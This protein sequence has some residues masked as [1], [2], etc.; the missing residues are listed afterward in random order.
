MLSTTCNYRE[1]NIAKL[2]LI[3][4]VVLIHCNL[5]PNLPDFIISENV[6]GIII[7][8]FISRYLCKICVP[9]FFM[10][11]GFLF[12]RNISIESRLDELF[13][14]Y[15]KK[16][17]TRIRSLVIPYCI[18]NIIGACV[19]LFKC[20]CFN[21]NSLGVI[22][23]GHIQ[24]NE[25]L[26]GFISLKNGYPYDFPL[27]FI[28][29]LICYVVLSP[30][31]FYLARNKWLFLISTFCLLLI[32]STYPDINAYNIVFFLIGSYIG[33]HKDLHGSMKSPDTGLVAIVLWITFSALMM[34]LPEVLYALNNMLFF[35]SDIAGCYAI[36]WISNSIIKIRQNISGKAIFFIFAVHGM[37]CTMIRKAM[38]SFLGWNSSAQLLL[39]YLGT[40]IVLVISSLIVYYLIDK[41]SPGLASILSGGRDKSKD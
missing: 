37:Y 8:R 12:F 23:D 20:Y 19:F 30:I 5:L 24:W 3:L 27:W 21:N 13:L 22:I 1:L 6:T 26:K 33:L 7:I 4:G 14:L 2:L 35:F 17:N 29:D 34:L 36:I 18:W 38:I 41:V 9:S 16:L 31:F 39:A 11:S 25:F 15:K 10:I 32:N 28:R 40:F